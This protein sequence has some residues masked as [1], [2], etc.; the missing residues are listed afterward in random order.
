MLRLKHKYFTRVGP[1]TVSPVFAISSPSLHKGWQQN[2]TRSKERTDSEDTLNVSTHPQ[3]Q[4]TTWVLV[5]V[6]VGKFPKCMT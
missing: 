4:Q 5:D 6:V 2:S 1:T 3:C